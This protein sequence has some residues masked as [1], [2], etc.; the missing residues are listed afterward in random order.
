MG[1]SALAWCAAMGSLAYAT[2]SDGG[3]IAA[4]VDSAPVQSEHC[5]CLPHNP[6]W[7]TVPWAALNRSVS[8]RLQESRDELHAC[9][10]AEGGD[11]NSRECAIALNNTDDQFLVM[12]LR[13][14]DPTGVRQN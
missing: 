6:C 5:R 3:T 4:A 9:L 7:A 12:V 8:G 11:I 14:P 1:S 13:S 10:P 2:A